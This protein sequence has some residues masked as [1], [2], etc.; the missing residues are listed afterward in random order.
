[1]LMENHMRWS[2]LIRLAGAL[3][4]VLCASIAVGDPA[5]PPA[6]PAPER[7]VWD[8]RPLHLTLGVGRE[9]IVRFPAPVEVGL[10]PTIAGALRVQ[11]VDE[12]VYLQPSQPF[13]ATRVQ[14][15]EIGSGRIILIDLRAIDGAAPTL[16][17]EVVATAATLPA[18]PAALPPL[19]AGTPGATALPPPP[20][21]PS[22]AAGTAGGA[23]RAPRE[24]GAPEPQAPRIGMVMLT[25]YAAQQLYAP[26]RLAAVPVPGIVRAAVRRK[27]VDNLFRGA[28]GGVLEARPVAAWRGGGLWVTAVR[29]H[30]AGG[31]ERIVDPRNLRGRW[32][33]ATFQHARLGAS[34]S[35][36]DVTCVYLVSAQPFEESL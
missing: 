1:M 25:R 32:L 34:G 9:R 5:E 16:P 19:P 15:R 4:L 27:P 29:L 8:K 10:P 6:A 33:A 18:L 13:D 3:W 35:D 21:P 28:D 24:A 14:I 22:A 20:I 30:N 17:V 26:E 23:G 11:V 7:L 31:S 36:T 12:T 2:R